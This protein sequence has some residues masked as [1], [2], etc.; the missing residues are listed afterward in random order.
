MKEIVQKSFMHIWLST[1]VLG[2]LK[3]FM[4]NLIFDFRYL[5]AKKKNSFKAE[6][7]SQVLTHTFNIYVFTSHI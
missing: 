4:F 6:M 7:Q 5:S 3:K 2:I 1:S